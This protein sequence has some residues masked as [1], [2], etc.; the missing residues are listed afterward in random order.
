M[1]GKT[2]QNTN[3]PDEYPPLPPED[4]QFIQQVVGSFLY[5]KRS[6]DSI[7]VHAFSVIASEQAE[8]TEKTLQKVEKF[9]DYMATNPNATIRYHASDMVLQAHSNASYLSAP[10][11]RS[12]AAG[13]IFLGSIPKNGEPLFLNGAILALS[14]ILKS[15][16]ASA[17]EAELGAL[18]VTA[19]KFKILRLT[20][21]ELGHP[22][23]PTPIHCDNTT[24]VGIVNNKIK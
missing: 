22:Q 1:F 4:K 23:P 18:F 3:P 2:S 20:L 12:R 8:P 24:A 11:A 21:A 19:Q 13:H 7:I 16:V 14:T 5:Y 9:L 17:A 10:Q 6:V 15:I